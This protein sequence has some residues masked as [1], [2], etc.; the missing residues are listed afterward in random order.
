MK[1]SLKKLT[2][3]ILS[4]LL[5]MGTFSVAGSKLEASADTPAEKEITGLCTGTIGRPTA[6]DSSYDG[7]W[8]GSYVYFG[9]Y[10]SEAMKYRVLDTASKDFGVKDEAAGTVG[11]LLLDCD[12]ILKDMVFVDAHGTINEGADKANEWKY[13]DINKWLNGDEFLGNPDDPD[14]AGA[15]SD[16]ER[17]AIAQSNKETPVTKAEGEEGDED[18]KGYVE[19]DT[20]ILPFA[21]LTGESIFLLD[22]KEATRESYGYKNTDLGDNTRKKNG[23]TLSFW[24]LRSPD[25]SD[26]LK[27]GC[28]GS[29]GGLSH[30]NVGSNIIGV[31]P[32]F[33]INLA[34]VIFSSVIPNTENEYKLTVRDSKLTIAADGEVKK[35]GNKVTVPYKVD[36]ENKDKVTRVTVLLLKEE[37]KAGK[38]VVNSSDEGTGGLPEFSYIK[39]EAEDISSGTGSFTLPDEYAELECGKDYFAYILAEIEN[40]GETDKEVKQTDYAS[41][42]VA[43]TIKNPE[44]TPTPEETPTPTPEITPT[45]TPEVTPTPVKLEDIE[46][47]IKEMKSEADLENT[48]FLP[49]KLKAGKVTKNSISYSWQKVEGATKYVIYG[50]KCSKKNKCKKITEITD[51]KYTLDKVDGKK[52]KKGTY[53]KLLIVAAD[54]E[55][56]VLAT[57]KVVHVATKGGK[58]TNYKSISIK[59]D[60]KIK[61]GKLSL[62][63]GKTFKLKVKTAKADKKLKL[64][65]HRKISFESDNPEVATV[66]KSG[67]IKAV[68]AGNCRIYAYTQNGLYKTLTVTVK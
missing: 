51:T 29:S 22:A 50:N 48:N 15:F 19:G 2:A 55:N 54:D 21:S 63:K 59:K 20:D 26:E 3:L 25:Y 8:Q 65:V 34:S 27:A 13:C 16:A 37:Y 52:L 11:S 17:N 56:N 60:K 28:V 43:I 40:T 36:G 66:S 62:K 30:I 45:P 18:G 42:P 39:L 14:K 64:K 68:G 32:A 61:K 7:D 47:Q 38:T 33:N 67:K 44:P 31:S 10:G 24:W 9:N 5:V 1:K 6:A 4:S 53:H 35:E 46:K 58:V 49:F 23:G 41:S 12:T 57:S